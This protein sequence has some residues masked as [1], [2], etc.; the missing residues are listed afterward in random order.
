MKT[1]FSL[2]KISAL[3]T[4]ALLLTACIDDDDDSSSDHDHGHEEH[5]HSLMVS[6]T[7]TTDLAVLEEGSPE[8][9]ET[10]AAANSAELLLSDTGEAAAVIT[11]G[12]VQFVVA[13]HEEEE[14]GEEE[15]HDEEEHELP[16][17][18]SLQIDGTGIKVAN[19][20][21]HFSVLATGTTQFVPYE[22]LE[23][24]A[25]PEAEDVAY[26]V[27]EEYPA[28][29]L[30]EDET[31]GLLTLVF[32][33]TNAVVY[34]GA[35]ASVEAEHTVACD[36]LNS[37]AHVGEFAVVSCDNATFSVKVEEA[38]DEHEAEITT[39]AGISTAVEWKS[40]AGVFVGLGA[41]NK[42]YVLEEEN[43]ALV[44][45]G[46]AF[47]APENM[48]TWG[49]DSSAADIFALTAS[50]LS[51][52]SH[53]GDQ[54]VSLTLDESPNATCADLTMATA[55]QAV[56]VLDNSAAK[57]YEIDKEEGATLYHVHGREDLAVSDVASAVNF[58]EVGSEGGH[59]H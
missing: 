22:S 29:L 5:A 46:T 37:T 51:V 3:A 14:E 4:S 25:T 28:L 35:T 23:E 52:H 13:H 26:T 30:H 44:L 12:S 2:L 34:E 36:V 18:S 9:L 8:A 59:E 43:E 32:D 21:G 7:S 54:E 11:A 57:F 38:G 31:H 48:C 16:E 17:V 49:I 58:H 50:A 56:F 15:A 19:T 55:T 40:R 45:E 10:A 20:N 42:F 39:I 41:D 24:G 27:A 33:G 47:D 53:E 6:R 1:P